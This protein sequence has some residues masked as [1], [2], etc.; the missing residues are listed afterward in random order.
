M[1]AISLRKVSGRVFFI[2]NTSSRTVQWPM[3][4]GT[5]NVTVKKWVVQYEEHTAMS[6]RIPRSGNL[7]K[8]IEVRTKKW[9]KTP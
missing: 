7:K 8:P 5:R 3:R 4:S 1:G 9:L 6:T 2:T